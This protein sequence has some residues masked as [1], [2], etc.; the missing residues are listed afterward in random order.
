VDKKAEDK[1]NKSVDTIKTA[2]SSALEAVGVKFETDDASV[3]GVQ[4]T[5]GHLAESAEGLAENR[6]GY[7]VDEASEGEVKDSIEGLKDEAEPL[8]KNPVGY[9]VDRASEKAATVNMKKL[10]GTA[11][12]LLG[13]IG[14]GFSLVAIVGMAKKFVAENEEIQGAVSKVR[15][16]WNDWKKQMDAT[17]DISR[18]LT[19]VIV[20]GLSQVMNILRRATDGFIR[21]GNRI[22]GV[23]K[24][25]KLLAI[26]AGAIFLALNAGKIL[27]FLKAFGIGL[28]KV[29]LKMF[30]IVAVVIIVA[31]LIEDLVRFMQG[32]DSLIG[33]LLEKFG[34]DGEEVRGMI[35][36]IMDALKGLLPFILQIA[37][38]IGGALLDV[39]KQL[40]PFL[41]EIIQ[42]IIPFIID[43]LKELIPF[44][45][46]IVMAIIPVLIDVIKALLPVVME[47]IKAVLPVIISLIKQLLPFVMEII[48]KVLPFIISLIERLLPLVMEII[49]KVL[50]IIISLI[51]RLL[52]L[53]MRIIDTILPIIIK[54]VETLIP[55]IMQIIDAILPVLIGLIEKLLPIVMQIIDTILPI[56]ISLIE[57]L[58]SIVMPILDMILPLLMTLLEALM[59]V[60]KFVAEL[61]GS[62]LGAAFDALI[63]IINAVMGI[64]QGLIDFITGIFTGDWSKAWEGVKNIFKNIVEGLSAIF[65]A[66]INFII[67]IINVFI[68]GL[69]KLKIPNWVPVVGGK[70][71]NIPLIPKLAKGSDSS[72]DTFIAGEE[73]PEL[74]T[75]AKGRKVFTANETGGIFQK[76]KDFANAAIPKPEGGIGGIGQA[77][78]DL[79]K[80][81]APPKPETVTAAAGNVENKSLTQNVEIT[82][83]FHGDRAGQQKSKEAMD[84]AGDDITGQLARGLAYLRG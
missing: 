33:S 47:I 81:G 15:E 34:I 67:D 58:I 46:E 44:L 57:L 51:E 14:I 20:R 31:L 52:P 40:L 77:I 43:L 66:P 23:D 28:K 11:R 18:R 1:V 2:A 53:V 26:S 7:V 38:T 54:L 30:A 12:K 22:G 79:A 8:E 75:G 21:L 36:E 72:P 29:G 82:N 19:R 3:Q 17:F 48:K 56:V 64:F 55:I 32:E 62:V 6:V 73:G 78:K 63:P 25:F 65:K 41:V 24:L 27:K 13:A 16:E 5:I 71:I 39:I 59:P 80:L 84:K 70:G 68:G 4:E 60:I 37:K 50:P 69:N 45:V 61:L 9:E 83:Q 35:R 49:N 42:M 74:I 10:R 76:L